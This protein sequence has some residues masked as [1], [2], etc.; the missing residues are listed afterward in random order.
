[1]LLV[2]RLLQMPR[3]IDRLAGDLKRAIEIGRAQAA[4]EIVFSLQEQGPWWTGNFARSW[5]V[6]PSLVKPTKKVG[7]RGDNVYGPTPQRTARVPGKPL[8]IP[9]ALSKS[10]FVGNEIEYAGFAAGREHATVP[11][12]L[13]AGINYAEHATRKTITPPMGVYWFPLYI[14]HQQFLLHDLNKGFTR[15]FN[16]AM[17]AGMS[18][19]SPSSTALVK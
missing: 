11:V 6:S 10:L 19:Q 14:T 18:I 8:V 5:V 7:G 17:G 1:V 4:S 3:S 16:E 2:A 13:S 9:T 15:G 12:G